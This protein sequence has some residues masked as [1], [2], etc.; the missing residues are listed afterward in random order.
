MQAKVSGSS[1]ELVG[2]SK[3]ETNLEA[4]TNQR[5]ASKTQGRM[6]ELVP[7][8]GE[9]DEAQTQPAVTWSLPGNCLDT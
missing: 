3:E 2:W 9:T 6:Y 8:A 1:W 7:G 5:E 4:S